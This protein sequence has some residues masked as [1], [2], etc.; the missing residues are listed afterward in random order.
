MTRVAQ[1]EKGV[2]CFMSVDPLTSSF[3]WNSAY[4]FA[5]GSPIA[6]SDLDGL[7]RNYE[8]IDVDMQRGTVE[9]V[10]VHSEDIYGMHD[11]GSGLDNYRIKLPVVNSVV[12]TVELGYLS[13]FQQKQRLVKNEEYRR[14]VR[15]YQGQRHLAA[16]KANHVN[17]FWN[18]YQL[19]PLKDAV[20]IA[21]AYVHDGALVAGLYTFVML[22]P[23]GTAQFAKGLRKGLSVADQATFRSS[24]DGLSTGDRVARITPEADHIAKANGWSVA[25]DI[26]KKNRRNGRSSNF[27]RDDESGQIF[28]LDTEK[29]TF[30]VYDKKGSHLGEINF[31]GAETGTAKSDR[32][33][34][35]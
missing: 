19:S 8:C 34:K 6:N 17:P 26:S 1:E 18:M 13:D 29:G 24:L 21:G 12:E 11:T 35:L 28:G 4:A 33:L 5:E 32:K 2:Q 30:E 10:V 31:S 25:T 7:E 14:K 3:P 15:M 20:D 23:E 9:T 27:Y 16:A 22:A